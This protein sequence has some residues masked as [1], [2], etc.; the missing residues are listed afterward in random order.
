MTLPISSIKQK[1]QKV[2]IL[3]YEPNVS[4]ISRHIRYILQ[5]LQSEN[6]E[7]WLLCSSNDDTIPSF[8]QNV[9]QVDRIS[10]VPPHRLFSLKG[11]ITT[12]KIIRDHNIDLIHIHNLQSIVWGYGGSI[13]A[14]CRKIVFTPHIDTACA[15]PIQ[16]IFRRM[17]RIFNTSTSSLIALSQAQKEWLLHWKIVNKEK[18]VVINNHIHEIEL[19]SSAHTDKPCISALCNLAPETFI[20]SQIG[21]LDRQKNPFFL[22]RIAKLVQKK[23]PKILFLFVG[24]GPLRNKLEKTIQKFNQQEN[25][26]LTGHQNNIPHLIKKT[27]VIALTSL[28]EGM[29]YVL[30]EAVCFKKVIIATDIPG[31][32]DLITDGETGFLVQDEKDFANKLITVYKSRKLR[33]DMGERGYQKNKHLFDIKNMKKPFYDIYNSTY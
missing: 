28:W 21:R 16:W 19:H 10:I 15:G 33:E 31:N 20:V 5:V 13:L 22:L 32:R 12:Q 3:F 4:G 2:L 27:D 9:I 7:F 24:D 29:P 8:F 17:W 23:F 1:K 11:L 25:V 14:G 30:L 6:H 18:I 26:I